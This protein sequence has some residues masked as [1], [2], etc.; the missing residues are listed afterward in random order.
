M[1]VTVCVVGE[2][3]YWRTKIRSEGGE[4]DGG[5][6]MLWSPRRSPL[7]SFARIN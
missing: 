2:K 6:S 1:C 7:E 4:G 3:T 5:D